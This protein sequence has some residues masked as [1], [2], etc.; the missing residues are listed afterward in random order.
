MVL[1]SESNTRF[2]VE[3]DSRKA[4]KIRELDA[5]GSLRHVR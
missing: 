2:L 5:E 4:T 3:V 1:F